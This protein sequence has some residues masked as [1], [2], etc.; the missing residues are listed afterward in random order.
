MTD[1][2]PIPPRAP[3]AVPRG[4]SRWFEI[5]IGASAILISV[6]SLVVAI[7]ANRTQE[8]M[9]AASVWPSLIFGTSDAA[10]D[11]TS[12][13][14]LDL[15][16]R[17][18]GPAR[19]RWAE[20]SHDDTPVRGADALLRACC[21][22]VDAEVD[23]LD[24]FTSGIQ[25]RVVGQDEWIKLLRVAPPKAPNPVYEALVRERRG[26]RLRLCYCSVLDDCW[27]LDS[28]SEEPQPVDRCRAPPEV[29]WGG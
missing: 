7:S 11:G 17:G 22:R 15:I 13:V 28:R 27:L 20:V 23:G 24:V 6:V 25:R 5:V 9:L 2:D 8:R 16:N 4:R 10:P 29:V 18:T 1:M 26:I 21:G 14:S 3:R 12:E 19:V